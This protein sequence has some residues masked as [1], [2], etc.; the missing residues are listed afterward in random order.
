[1]SE[2]HRK[3]G[4]RSRKRRKSN[5]H[6]FHCFDEV[7]V[8]GMASRVANLSSFRLLWHCSPTLACVKMQMFLQNLRHIE[9]MGASIEVVTPSTATHGPSLDLSR[10]SCSIVMFRLAKFS[11]ES[12]SRY[13]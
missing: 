10:S 9:S 3:Q 8:L 7:F 13:V 11:V 5:D 4:E 1:M 2:G 6:A 12:Q